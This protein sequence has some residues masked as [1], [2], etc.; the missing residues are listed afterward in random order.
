MMLTVKLAFRNLIGAGLRTWLNVFVLS[1]AFVMIIFVQSLIKGMG[2]YAVEIS[3]DYEYG[4]G[5]YRHELYDPYDPLT[6]EDSHAA[7]SPALAGLIE[8]GEATP[9]LVISGAIFP[10]GRVQSALL[11][12]IDPGQGILKIPSGFLDTDTTKAIPALIGSRM[13]R[14]TKI[15]IGDYVT[16]RWRDVNGMFDADDVQIV[17]IMHNAAPSVD[18]G[19]IWIPLERLREML[20][21][22]GEATF[23]VLKEGFAGT[24]A[25]DQTWIHNSPEALLASVT[26]LIKA[27]A[28]TTNVLYGLLLFMGLLAIFDTQVLSVWRRRREI[29]TLMALGMQRARVIWLFTFEGAL[30]GL[31]ALIVGAVYGLPLMAIVMKTGIPLPSAVEDSGFAIPQALYPSY[32]ARLLLGTTLLVLISVTVVSFLPASRIAKLKPTDALRGKTS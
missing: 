2:D 9:I 22:P 30:H 28:G 5:Q 20:Q 24:A 7:L 23:V 18:Q 3:V 21:T 27:K 8:R 31:L 32:G 1:L 11:K 19:Q 26:E 16:V 12:G 15:A 6:L 17:Q 25:G 10:E 14:Q 13:A 4:G 29:G